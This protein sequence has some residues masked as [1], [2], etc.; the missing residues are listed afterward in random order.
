MDPV[1]R[2]MLQIKV[3]QDA[4]IAIRQGEKL[5]DVA[6]RLGV[7]ANTLSRRMGRVGLAN[8][9][10][11]PSRP[12]ALPERLPEDTFGRILIE[13]SDTTCSKETLAHVLGITPAAAYWRAQRLVKRGM[14]RRHREG[15]HFEYFTTA[16]GHAALMN[17]TLD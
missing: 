4:H 2:R 8:R 16:R 10:G 11:R 5:E 3:L 1:M 13:C 14:L 15:Q 9:R 17:G 12:L 7:H 6:A